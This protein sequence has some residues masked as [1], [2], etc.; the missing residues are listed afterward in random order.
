MAE[1]RVLGPIQGF[2]DGVEVDLGG[3]TQRRLLASLVA[4]PK[5]VV[6]VT[7]L[8]GHLWGDDPPPS[9]PASIQSYVSRLRRS[10]GPDGIETIAPG[11]RLGGDL[12]IDSVRFLEIAGSLPDEPARRLE[13]IETALGLWH[14]PPFEDFDHVDYASHRLVEVKHH[15]EEEKASLLADRGEYAAAVGVLQTVTGAEPLRES[16]WVALGLTLARAGRQAEA[17]RVMDRYRSNLSEIGLEPGPAFVDAEAKVFEATLSPAPSARLPLPKMGTSFVGREPEV[18]DLTRLLRSGRLVTVVGPGGMGKTRLAIEVASRWSDAEVVMVRLESLREEDEV[19]SSALRS[20]GGETRG[21]PAESVVAQLTRMGRTLLV[22]DNVEHIIESTASLVTAILTS[23]E[24]QLLV[25]SRE[26]LNIPGE[27]VLSLGPLEPASAIELFRDRALAI[28]PAFEASSATL[29]MLCEELDYMPLAIEMAAARSKALSPDEIL[30][31]LSRRYGLLDKPLRGGAERHR[32]LDALVEWSYDLLAPGAQRVFERLSVVTGHFDVDLAT[33][34]GGFGQV[35][36]EEVPATLAGLVE[37]SLVQRT[38]PGAFR[39]LPVLKSFAG[40][41]LASAG[42]EEETRS[43]HA[44][45]FARLAGDIGDGL[46][47]PEETMWIERANAAVDDVTSALAWS[48]QTGDLDSAQLILEGLFDWFYHRQPPSLFTWGDQVLSLAG[49]HDVRAV[50]SAWAALTHLK[51]GDVV[52]AMEVAKLGTTVEGPAARFAWFVVG[53][54]ARHQHRQEEAV[55]AYRKQLVRAS[56]H[57]DR[58]GVIDAM[59]GE[60]LALASGGAFDRAVDIARDLEKLAADVGAPSYRA[61]A[62]YALA[63]AI[64]LDQPEKSAELLKES[65]EQAA[66]VNNH[67]IQAMAKTSAVT[68]LAQIGDQR[69]AIRALKE[70]C[71]LWERMGMPAHQWTIVQQVAAIMAE[72]GDKRVAGI[73][74]AASRRGGSR[75]FGAAQR[76]WSEATAAIES[77]PNW[78]EWSA[79]GERLDLR[80]AVYLARSA[81][82]G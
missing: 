16:A 56:A 32:S 36:P 60:T 5:Q 81:M 31:R 2:R 48:A 10:L 62:D 68:V 14:G 9:G 33:A 58:I 34:L 3:P 64:V 59:A 45:W 76:Q 78:P 47:T 46:C 39:L 75:P 1:I 21:D 17:V 43:I 61:Y 40:E 30:T 82:A 6:S 49:D 55:D 26:P 70:A 37:R 65:V 8:L 53:E 7:T 77:D 72:R 41:R 69:D 11:Y 50:A 35:T 25:T 20:L 18:A 57:G 54:V 66:S 79:E 80:E 22:L 19:A 15:L 27:M 12:E 71:D 28:D 67:F 13:A 74:L 44:R 29:D 4:Q 63:E 52:Q 73:L 42:D 38:G 24:A 23:T 51:R